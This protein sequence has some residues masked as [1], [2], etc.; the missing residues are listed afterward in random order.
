MTTK[1]ILNPYAGRWKGREKRSEVEKLMKEAGIDFD[2]VA[3]E[4]PNH[5]TDLAYQAVKEGYTPIVSAGGDGS[6]SEVMNGVVAAAQELGVAPPPLGMLPLGSAND[7][8]VNLGLPID[9]PGAVKVIAAGQTRCI[10]LGE[11]TAWDISK[12]HFKRGTSIIIAPSD[13]N[14]ASP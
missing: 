7:L 4:A 11:V 14:H 8:M 13:W 2:L 9:I 1:I 10:D 5:G 3:T 6:V 12:V